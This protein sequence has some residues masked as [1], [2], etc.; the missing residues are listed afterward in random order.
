MYNVYVF[1]VFRTT[2]LKHVKLLKSHIASNEYRR[3]LHSQTNYC[4]RTKGPIEWITIFFK[5]L[6]LAFVANSYETVM[7]EK[8]ILFLIG[9]IIIDISLIIEVIN[10]VLILWTSFS[11]SFNW[12]YVISWNY[13]VVFLRSFRY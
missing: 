7:R 3:N 8:Y 10:L 12:L 13:F 6:I 11:S 1:V 9:K 5:L 2:D 4:V